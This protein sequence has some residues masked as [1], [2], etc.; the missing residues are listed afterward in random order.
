MY[1]LLSRSAIQMSLATYA[2]AVD[3]GNIPEVLSVFTDYAVFQPLPH[4][5][6]CFGHAGISRFFSDLGKQMQSL[7]DIDPRSFLLSH[8]LTTSRID[9]ESPVK[10]KGFTRF[11]VMSPFGLD[12]SG[13]YTDT[14]ETLNSTDWQLSYRKITIDWKAPSSPLNALLKQMAPDQE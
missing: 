3:R 9:F 4:Y 13:Y 10:A 6:T 11:L 8:H 5:P 14:L 1:E 2:S 7:P 12:H